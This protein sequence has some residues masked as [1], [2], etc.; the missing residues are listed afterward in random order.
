MM[1]RTSPVRRHTRFPVRWAMVYG[2][3]GFLSEGTVLDV[4]QIG[5]RLAGAMPVQPG[6]RLTLQLWPEGKP[7]RM[8]VEAT[9][10]WV[11]GCEFA[12]DRP[13]LTADDQAWV[14]R[15]LD[16]NLSRSL[17][18]NATSRLFPE[19]V[20]TTPSEV[21]GSRADHVLTQLRGEIL[22]RYA[23]SMSGSPA[24]PTASQQKHEDTLRLLTGMQTRMALR[25]RMGWDSVMN[26]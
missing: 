23:D 15:F 21:S 16:Q 17:M 9:V 20:T 22:K 25:R 19:A 26:N 14:T 10:L 11:K 3:E 13:E 8:R 24:E 5:W 4:T 7:D 12:V 6:M 1:N 18:A 2:C